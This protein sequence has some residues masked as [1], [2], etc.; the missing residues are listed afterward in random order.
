VYRDARKLRELLDQ[1]DDVRALSGV[2]ET[3]SSETSQHEAIVELSPEFNTES[4]EHALNPRRYRIVFVGALSR[5]QTSLINALAGS[6]VL[7]DD[8]ATEANFPIHIR[9]GPFERASRLD[10]DGHWKEIP[11]ESAMQQATQTAVLL[12]VPWK[13]PPEL[14]L[15]HTPAFD[16]G[17]T[18]AESTALA[19]AKEAGEIVALF[20][21]QLSD[22]ELNVYERVAEYKH[23]MRF[24]HTIADNETPSERSSVVDLAK[25]YLDERHIDTAR[26]FIVSA[27]EDMAAHDAGRASA[28]WNELGALRETLS[29]KAEEHMRRQNDRDRAEFEQKRQMERSSSLASTSTRLGFRRAI[30][31]LFRKR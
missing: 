26:I 3:Q 13:F 17:R 6:P 1:L 10:P 22:T 24:V 21:R 30:Q 18:D 11:R 5:G 16:S 29:A 31:N 7:S 19:A 2:T 25:H 23:P 12:E 4:Y 28:A 20:S 9:Y 15:V 14:V 8:G 27:R